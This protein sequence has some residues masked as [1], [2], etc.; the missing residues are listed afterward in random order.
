ML[1][2]TVHN[3]M[4]V[5]AALAAT[6]SVAQQNFDLDPTFQTTIDQDY[7]SS[8]VAL[9][10]GDILVSGRLRF[11]GEGAFDYRLGT[12][13]QPTGARRSGFSAFPSMG[14]K[15]VIWQDR[16]YAAAGQSVLRSQSNGIQ[17]PTFIAM[18]LGPYFLSLQGGDYHVFPDGRILFSGQHLL[19]DTVRD[20]EGLYT[21]IWFSNEGYLDTTRIH[22]QSNGRM[23]EFEAYPE[24]SAPEVEGKFLCS[25]QGTQYEGQAVGKVFRIHA[26]GALDTTYQSPLSNFGWVQVIHPFPDGSAL[27]GG[28]MKLV[29]GT[30]TLSLLK[31]LPDGS[32]DPDFQLLDYRVNTFFTPL[33]GVNDIEQLEDGRMIVVGDFETVEGIERECI[34]M[35]NSDGTVVMDQFNGVVCGDFENELV[36]HRYLAG[37][38]PAPDGSYYIYGAYHGYHDGTTNYPQ[39][40]F[41]SRLYGL[42]VGIAEHTALPPLQPYPNP[43][44]GTFTLE[45]PLKAPAPLE[46]LD[47]SGRVVHTQLLRPGTHSHTVQSALPAGVYLLRVQEAQG[48]RRG[49]VV[50]E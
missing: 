35:L 19:D 9:T 26:D 49:R 48:V 22:R 36:P 43:G 33:T 40:R 16:F 13:L 11:S 1:A 44:G 42:D 15:V 3:V 41:I 6:S 45:V 29:G 34:A 10:D 14:G 28:A 39:Q 17:D 21:L 7:V 27:L 38:T 32:L 37:I 12:L 5:A 30:D 31:L 20:F 23:F 8:V 18:N 24:G 4:L 50:V 47:A 46:L 25:T 2:R